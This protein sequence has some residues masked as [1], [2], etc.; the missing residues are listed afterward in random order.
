M[1]ANALNETTHQLITKLEKKNY[2]KIYVDD[3]ICTAKNGLNK[4]LQPVNNLHI[5]FG[6]TVEELG[7]MHQLAFLDIAVEFDEQKSLL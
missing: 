4:L 2:F 3:I 5:K 6:F 1:L 7:E